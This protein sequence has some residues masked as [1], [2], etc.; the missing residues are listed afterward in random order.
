M[1]YSASSLLRN[2]RLSTYHP[3]AGSECAGH[4]KSFFGEQRG[5]SYDA[6]GYCT[7][8][9]Q[10]EPWAVSSPLGG[11]SRLPSAMHCLKFLLRTEGLAVF[12]KTVQRPFCSLGGKEEV[13]HFLILSLE[14]QHSRGCPATPHLFTDTKKVC[15]YGESSDWEESVCVMTQL[16]SSGGTVP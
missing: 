15:F 10:S 16:L 9:G 13:L 4:R 8:E 3:N 2:W 11:Q 6:F 5:V 14:C 1:Y 7:Q 12:T